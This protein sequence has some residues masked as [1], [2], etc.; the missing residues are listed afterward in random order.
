MA[1]KKNYINNADLLTQIK[2]SK[3]NGKMSDELANMLVLLT[4]RYASRGN[5]AGYSF[6]EDMQSHAHV[7]LC[8]AW[9]KFN[10]DKSNNPFAFYTQCIH[11]AFLQFLKKE[12]RLREIKD[13]ELIFN[14]LNP[15]F[16][17]QA[18]HEFQQ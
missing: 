9:D 12:K 3:K 15:S 4:K 2:L 10:D 6:I 18:E 7:Q 16:S 17:A 1:R 5:F 13:L 8:I 11:N 14:G